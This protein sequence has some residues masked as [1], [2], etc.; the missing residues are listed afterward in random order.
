[1]CRDEHQPLIH[2]EPRDNWLTYPSQLSRQTV[3]TSPYQTL[4]EPPGR[5]SISILLEVNI[6]NVTI[7]INGSP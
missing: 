1:M 2:G 3:T 5:V 6:Y 7:L 4:E